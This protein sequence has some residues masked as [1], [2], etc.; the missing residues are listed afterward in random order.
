M[1][2]NKGILTIAA[3]ALLA[4]VCHAA[5]GADSDDDRT[6]THAITVN[7]A[8]LPD[9]DG[10]G[11]VGFSDFVIFAGV[12]GA[13]QGDEKYDARYDLN[14]D[15]EIGFSD[16]VIFAQNFGK[17]VPSPVVAISDTNL[18]AAIEAALDKAAGTPITQ[19]EM[20]TMNSLTATKKGISDLTG[21]ESA[22]NLQNLNLS[23]NNITDISPLAGLTKLR[24]LHLLDNNI[25][26]ISPLAGLTKLR[27]LELGFND[28]TDIS[29]LE[30][31]TNLTFLGLSYNYFPDI[32]SLSGL[33]NLTF[34]HL[35]DNDITDISPLSGLTNL[36]ELRLSNN[37]IM[38]ISPLSGLTNLTFLYLW[39]NDITDISP[40]S[41]L[42][43]LK[44]LHLGN[45]DIMDISPL[46]GLTSLEHLKLDD[47][48]ITDISVLSGLTNLDELVLSNNDITDISVLASLTSLEFLQVDRNNLT[49]VSA[50]AGLVRLIELNLGFNGITDI[51]AL[52]GLTRLAELDLRRNP[53][54]DAS[55]STDIP[56]LRARG[57]NVSFDEVR[58]TN[59]LQIYNDNVFVL[60]VTENLTSLW[61]GTSGP[62]L[63]DYVMRFYEHFNDEFDFL[64]FFP[65][66]LWHQLGPGAIDGAFYKR[67]KNATKGIGVPI[68]SD[69]S[70][71][72]S[73]E[74]LQGVIFFNYNDPS[75]F[76]GLLLHE[77][78]H[79]WG[80]FVVST[81]LGGHWGFSS[82]GG[83]LDC[84]DIS[85]MID[86]GG[87]KFS[88][89]DPFY[90]RSSEQ[91][92]PIELYLAGFIPPE[93][94]PDFQVAEDG[95]WLSDERGDFV[96]DDNGYRMFTASQ[97]KTYT[98]EDIIAKHG[99]RDPD[100]VQSQKDFRA[101]VILLTG[102]DYPATRETL[103]SLSDD[104]LWFSHAGKDESGPPV[105]NFYEATGGRG[106][107]TMDGLSQ[108]QRRAGANKPAASSF[109]T[110]PPPI[111]DHWDYGKGHEDT[112]RTLRH[113]PEEVE[114]P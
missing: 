103:E 16:F 4:F 48:D 45:N 33:T 23:F 41:G 94:V 36:K 37:D 99:R 21:L 71:R 49:D 43:N 67:V 78:M 61:T 30:G 72:G 47:N 28:I 19:A 113:I 105:T 40:L 2:S 5:I 3:L 82:S 53:L 111:V 24:G 66:V 6:T 84:Y 112:D 29:P 91:Y 86:H 114:E 104:V 83:Y 27:N 102:E 57:V 110:P 38:D 106:T 63:E 13:R 25:T 85:N 9:F 80:N 88:T 68:F 55:K 1:F 90:S 8:S 35:W 39:G 89:P 97:F 79:R 65:N 22:T 46:S 52:A 64:I 17:E 95:K 54:N 56:A 14:D 77:L 93:D 70:R 108:F 92:S 20:A 10:D 12:F 51:S 98:I 60:P 73:A 109:G 26:D 15:G 59:E 107:I 18:R 58:P 76:R 44:E 81:S 34:L 75:M 11:T 74:R 32:S 101:A 50:L 62:P 7:A 69:N 42:T 31:L 100:H 96:K 87:G